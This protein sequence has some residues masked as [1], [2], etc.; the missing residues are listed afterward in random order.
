MREFLLGLENPKEI[1]KYS[2]RRLRGLTVS[3]KEK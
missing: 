3:E 2:E 1:K